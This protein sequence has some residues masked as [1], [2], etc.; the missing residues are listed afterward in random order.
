M[1]S[2]NALF[3]LVAA[4]TLCAAC[5]V[6]TES[7]EGDAEIP[8]GTTAAPLI[9]SNDVE[10]QGVELQGVELQGVE[11]QGVELQG[12]ELQGV[13][14]QGTQLTGVDC[15]GDVVSGSDFIGST[16]VG[17]LSNAEPLTLR[18][19]AITPSADPDVDLFTVSYQ[20]GAGW[21]SLCGESN[22]APIKAIP[23]MGRWD[24]SRGTVSGGSY[25]DDPTMFT[26]ACRTAVL[27]KCVAM[28]YKPWESV[29]EC[30]EGSCT[31]RSLRHFH[32]ACTRM[33]R[34]DYCGDGM[35]HTQ[36]GRTINVWDNFAI[37]ERESVHGTHWKREAEWEPTGA[38][39]IKN[40]RWDPGH[41]TKSYVQQ[42]CRARKSPGGAHC[43]DN[44]SAFF[45]E[46]GFSTP[47]PV[48][49][50]LRN[51]AYFP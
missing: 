13:E 35:P 16:M 23:L 49:A 5:T 46:H 10:L 19:D 20:D 11:L 29:T 27:A 37:Q 12:V 30:D 31:E 22:G 6:S 44:D 51:E 17:V 33:M 47:M 40:F 21:T 42:H 24:S 3:A 18:I 25:I 34:A 2:P 15:N 45:T 14:L 9:V 32:Q 8:P 41:V 48:R 50:L 39:C 38:M 43:F 26:F 4:S 1:R 36:N 28:G 7:A